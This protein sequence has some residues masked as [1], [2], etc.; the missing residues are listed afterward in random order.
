MSESSDTYVGGTAPELLPAA[1]PWKMHKAQW[2][3][4]ARA[5]GKNP[6]RMPV[7]VEQFIV[8]GDEKDAREAAGLWNFL[9]KAFKGYHEIE[10]PAE[11]ER[12][13][14]AELPLPKVYGEW[15]VS[16]DPAAHVQAIEKLFASGVTIVNIHS[17][18]PDQARVLDFFGKQV[19]P[20]LKGGSTPGSQTG[21]AH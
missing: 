15:T 2:Q 17:G 18:Q 21:A 16:T 8:V 9:P 12:R 11:I 3:A 6:D 19:L 10:S 20:Q 14:K 7:L 5:A 4:G 13:A 1:L